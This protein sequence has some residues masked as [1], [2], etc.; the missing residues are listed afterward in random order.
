VLKQ[1]QA[2]SKAE[3]E[4]K[5]IEQSRLCRKIKEQIITSTASS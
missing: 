4:S 2:I 5:I 1:N 3:E